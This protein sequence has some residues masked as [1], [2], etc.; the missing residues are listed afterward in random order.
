MVQSDTVSAYTHFIKMV[1]ICESGLVLCDE[2]YDM[3]SLLLV[4]MCICRRF[5]DFSMIFFFF[6]FRRQQNAVHSLS[7]SLSI[8][9]FLPLFLCLSAFFFLI[10]CC[11]CSRKKA[12]KKKLYTHIYSEKQPQKYDYK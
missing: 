9:L 10:C 6:I 8:S 3:C 7:T 12:T 11:Y 4:N 1:F 2:K 5:T